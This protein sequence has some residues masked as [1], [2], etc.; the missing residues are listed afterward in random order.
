MSLADDM[1]HIWTAYDKDPD[2]GKPQWSN[3]D[4]IFTDIDFK[5]LKWFCL[6]PRGYFAK[7]VQPTAYRLELPPKDIADYRLTFRY[8]RIQEQNG[9]GMFKN[10]MMPAQMEIGCERVTEDNR[11]SLIRF[12]RGDV[13]EPWKDHYPL[14]NGFRMRIYPTNETA[15]AGRVISKSVLEEGMLVIYLRPQVI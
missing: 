1:T 11:E 8:K 10:H 7:E 2:G 15:I 3:K 14:Q 9:P 13:V 5:N 6:E 4:N 12:E